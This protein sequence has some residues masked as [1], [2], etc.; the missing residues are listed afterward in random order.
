MGWIRIAN[1]GA[2]AP[3]PPRPGEPRDPRE[4]GGPHGEGRDGNPRMRP[5]VELI[6]RRSSSCR[7][8]AW[9][10]G[11]D[12]CLIHP[13]GIPEEKLAERRGRRPAGVSSPSDEETHP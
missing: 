3:E 4:T 11:D 5:A 8:C 10:T 6:C 7:H 2:P 1:D 12:R 9:R 13:A